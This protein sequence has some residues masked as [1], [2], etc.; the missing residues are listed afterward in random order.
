MTPLAA[1][2]LDSDEPQGWVSLRDI[3]RRV[4]VSRS[5]VSMALRNCRGVAPETVA[6]VQSVARELGYRPNALLSVISQPKRGQRAGDK[7]LAEIAVVSFARYHELWRGERE[8]VAQL[9]AGEQVFAS[10]RGYRL[11]V[12]ELANDERAPEQLGER[13]YSRGCEAAI[14]LPTRRSDF[15]HRFP[16]H[17]FTSVGLAS[18][19]AVGAL[20]V[21]ELIDDPV[22]KIAAVWREITSRGYQRPGLVLPAATADSLEAQLLQG[23]LLRAQHVEGGAHPCVPWL[24]LRGPD[25]AALAR[26]LDREHPDVVIGFDASVGTLLGAAG[27]LC[28]EDI[29]FVALHADENAAGPVPAGFHGTRVDL[30]RAAIG[31]IE[32]QERLFARGVPA[33][34]QVIH[35]PS[36]WRDGETLRDRFGWDVGI[37]A[38]QVRAAGAR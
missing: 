16:W 27:H 22:A 1:S 17:Y 4:G 13:I 3:A 8:S 33:A 15:A 14:V 9:V 24:T 37:R 36:V 23:A 32:R 6:R 10:Q 18:G 20:P 11:V 19:G 5:T 7:P 31:H 35:L 21:H 12:H 2:T 25:V 38:T 28:P 29:G 30:L 26:W 34:K